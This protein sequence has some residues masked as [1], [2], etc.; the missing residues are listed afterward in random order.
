[1]E[2]EKKYNF[3]LF[4][5]KVFNFEAAETDEEHSVDG[6]TGASNIDDHLFLKLSY[7]SLAVND[8]FFSPSWKIKLFRNLPSPIKHLTD[9]LFF[10]SVSISRTK[11]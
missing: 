10:F 1:M 6:D 7:H 11:R 5:L 2:L 8:C 4:G 9:N 3:S